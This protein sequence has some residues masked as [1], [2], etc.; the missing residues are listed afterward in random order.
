MRE[1]PRLCGFWKCVE[2]SNQ[3][4]PVKS[5]FSELSRFHSVKKS[6]DPGHKFVHVCGPSAT[7]VKQRK[8]AH[9]YAHRKRPSVT[10]TT[11]LGSEAST[12][13]E[14]NT[15]LLGR[16]SCLSGVDLVGADV[17]REGFGNRLVEASE[18]L[19][20]SLSLTAKRHRQR[21]TAIIGNCWSIVRQG[22]V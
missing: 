11:Q 5:L 16:Y 10:A 17:F 2:F 4:F 13:T 22:L 8:R 19:S 9:Q 3:S 1:I 6:F 14:M 12:G 20:H 18:Q 15:Y 7:A 21:L